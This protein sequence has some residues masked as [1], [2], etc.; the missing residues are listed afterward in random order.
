MLELIVFAL[1]AAGAGAGAMAI[2]V[3]AIITIAE[4]FDWFRSRSH[5]RETDKDVIAFTLKEAL[6]S[7]KHATV[8]GAFA[9]SDK[10]YKVVQG[11]F[12]TKTG[13]VVDSRQIH[14]DRV[15]AKVREAHSSDVL[16]VYE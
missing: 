16:A 14:S 3:L 7:G 11:F 1:L 2:V 10:Q 13:Q 8:K 15:D 4:I 9:S 12:N 5:L 6:A